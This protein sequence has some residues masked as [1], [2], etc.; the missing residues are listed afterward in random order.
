M[1]YDTSAAGSDTFDANATSAAGSDTDNRPENEESPVHC[2]LGDD[3]LVGGGAHTKKWSHD[4]VFP[5]VC[6]Q[7]KDDFP[8]MCRFEFQ[9]Y[10]REDRLFD[11]LQTEPDLIPCDIP[12]NLLTPTLFVQEMKE[13]CS[14]HSITV[15]GRDTKASLAAKLTDHDCSP[16]CS[17]FFS[18]MK[19]IH[20]ET[21]NEANSKA[22]AKIFPLGDLKEFIADENVKALPAKT[23]CTLVRLEPL[24]DVGVLHPN[25][26]TVS[27]PLEILLGRLS[28]TGIKE[29]SRYHG[30]L[31]STQ[32]TRNTALEQLRDHQ[33]DAGC[34]PFACVFQ[35][36]HVPTKSH[37][38][39]EDD[40]VSFEWPVFNE[41]HVEPYPPTAINKK[42]IARCVRGYTDNLQPHFIEEAACCVCAQLTPRSGLTTFDQ[43]AYS[44]SLL[45]DTSKTRRERRDVSDPIMPLAGPVLLNPILSLANGLWLGDIPGVLKD[46]TLGE[47]ALISRVRRNRSLVRVSAGHYKMIANVIAFPNP[48]AKVFRRLP[49]RK[50]DID[51]VI[52]VIFTGVT[53]PS[54]EDL[55]RTPVLVRRARVLAALRWLRLNHYDYADLIIDYD[56]LNTYDES[57][58]PVKVLYNKTSDD[59]GNT[60]ASA[61]PFN[62]EEEERV[63]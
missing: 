1:D 14:H 26:F 25:E 48:T 19:P 23:T 35:C 12:L 29:T 60:P 20:M 57:G 47:K 51:D 6:P 43:D 42:D 27:L 31:V 2:P 56:A 21:E 62:D 45:S 41:P 33:C 46:L 22:L 63:R 39:R 3:F 7:W 38:V 30:L 17:V 32:W 9:S 55:K 18:L 49:P 36:H 40:N 34:S 11:E 5:Y 52:A 58:V 44:L 15:I 59:E 61:K 24:S 28:K 8:T 10:V 37:V 16:A 4:E 53:P 54:D 50:E 13:L